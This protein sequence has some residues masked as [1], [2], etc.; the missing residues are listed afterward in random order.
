MNTPRTWQ[1]LM[2]AALLLMFAG[3]DLALAAGQGGDYLNYQEPKPAETSWLSTIA[4]VVTLLVTF[5]VVIGLAYFTSRFVGQ[6][7][8]RYSF[9]GDHKV[10]V[11]LPLG[12]S[13]GVYVVEVAGRF[14]VLGVTDHNVN[15]L[16]EITDPAEIERLRATSPAGQ[17]RQFDDVFQRHLAS[18]QQMSQ[19]FPAVFG[20]YN[21][22]DQEKDREKR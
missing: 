20:H 11:S 14:L 18:L 16:A 8:G 13:R 15:L 5:V 19:K 12:A 10:V 21:R 2:L 17:M 1:V 3:A 4:Y 9:S 7:M 22:T 6:K